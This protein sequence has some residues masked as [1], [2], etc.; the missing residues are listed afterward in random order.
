MRSTLLPSLHE[1]YYRLPEVGAIYTPDVLVFRDALG[2]DLPKAEHYYV[3]IVSAAMLRF[4][5]VDKDGLVNVRDEEMVM[6]KMRAVMRVLVTKGVSRIVLGAWGCGAYGNPVQAVAR[7][8]MR[9]LLGINDQGKG[10]QKRK[11]WTGVEEVVFAITDKGMV[12]VFRSCFE[13]W[14][15]L[16]ED[17]KAK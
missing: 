17:L 6:E 2:E 7:A 4:P 1:H 16:D 3:N 15:V 8:W 9:V 13:D 10:R 14:L 11:G 12:E 5:D